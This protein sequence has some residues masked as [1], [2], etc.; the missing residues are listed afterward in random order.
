MRRRGIGPGLT[1]FE[2]VA[3]RN[4]TAYSAKGDEHNHRPS[5]WRRFCY[6]NDLVPE[7]EGEESQNEESG[8]SAY[9]NNRKQPVTGVAERAFRGHDHRERKRRRSQAAYHQNPATVFFDFP[10]QFIEFRLTGNSLHA[11]FPGFPGD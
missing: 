8:R 4:D 7:P 5:K 2:P 11:F 1:A 6:G 10:L 9:G 3:D